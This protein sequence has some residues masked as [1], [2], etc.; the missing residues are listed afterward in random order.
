MTNEKCKRKQNLP[1]TIV[2]IIHWV[3]NLSVEDNTRTFCRI[4]YGR[5]E[6]NT[7]KQLLTLTLH[8]FSEIS[9]FNEDLKPIYFRWMLYLK[10]V[11]GYRSIN[12]VF[13]TI[14]T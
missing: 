1:Y 3:P 4:C 9:N 7:V 14:P 6:E 10:N 12:N 5:E 13:E 11:Y 8:D 2:D